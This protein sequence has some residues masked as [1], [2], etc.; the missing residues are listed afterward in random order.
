MHAIHR[1]RESSSAAGPQAPCTDG[2]QPRTVDADGP[3]GPAAP[4]PS[5]PLPS[6]V[7]GRSPADSTGA[8]APSEWWLPL[9]RP[10]AEPIDLCTM[11]Y[12]T[13]LP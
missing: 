5:S 10:R 4:R 2:T 11:M 6:S 8:P 1:T 13:T 12:A 3:T 9:D 7:S